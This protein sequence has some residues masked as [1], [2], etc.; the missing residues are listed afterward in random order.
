M[1]L[2][3]LIKNNKLLEF[4]VYHGTDKYFDKFDINKVGSGADVYMKRSGFAYGIYLADLQRRGE[5]YSRKMSKR[6]ESNREEYLY[7]VEI[8][9]NSDLINWNENLNSNQVKK[10]ASQLGKDNKANGLRARL[11]ANINN[12]S[13]RGDKIYNELIEELGSQKNA[14]NFLN[15]AGVDGIKYKDVVY[16]KDGQTVNN[17][18][19]YIIFDDK[20]IKIKRVKN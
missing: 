12:S 5:Q 2:K 8:D 9:N 4:T 11:L 10:I 7:T 18:H 19:N 15:K 3:S 1:K 16:N 13:I 17:T 6:P 14:S 20:K